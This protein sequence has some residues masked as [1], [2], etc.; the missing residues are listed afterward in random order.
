VSVAL[1]L[2]SQ[3]ALAHGGH[4][5]QPAAAPAVVGTSAADEQTVITVSRDGAGITGTAW[6]QSCPDGSGGDC[7]CKHQSVTAGT[8]QVSIADSSGWTR[9]VP[10]PSARPA[11][12]S[13]ETLPQQPFVSRALPRAPPSFS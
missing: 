13:P 5:A 9:P 1:A 10:P 2:A 3:L 4:H 12:P 7:C 6:S 11:I 8:A